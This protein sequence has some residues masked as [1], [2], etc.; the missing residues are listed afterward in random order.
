MQAT[1]TTDNKVPDTS[2]RKKILDV[3]EQLMAEKGVDGVTLNEIVRKSGQRNASALQYHFGGK[4]GLVQAIFDKHTPAIE[5]RRVVYLNQLSSPPRL[6]EIINALILPL[7][8]EM[9]NPDGGKD[10]L[11]FIARIQ[12]HSL[13]NQAEADREHHPSLER[14]GTLLRKF[15]KEKSI[16]QCELR[17]A[18]IRNTLLHN[19]AD[20]C[21][22]SKHDPE[23]DHSCRKHFI[24][25]LINSLMTILKPPPE[26]LNKNIC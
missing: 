20:Y 6:R 23:F 15:N 13:I 11:L 24:E 18:M 25:L 7:V 22:R 5:A 1:K 9:D 12:H 2:T 10:Y 21:Q 17:A 19:L 26:S 8:E 4:P 16:Q 14:V 3:A